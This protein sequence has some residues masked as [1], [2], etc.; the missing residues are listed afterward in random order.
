VLTGPNFG[1]WNRV[2][3]DGRYLSFI[4]ED[5]NNLGV[6]EL[7]TGRVR[8]VTS[9]GIPVDKPGEQYP[10]Q[11]VFSP[12]SRQIA[13]GWCFEDHCVLRVV[14][15]TENSTATRSTLYDNAGVENISPTDWSPDGKWISAMIQR[16]DRTAQIGLVNVADGSL[17]GPDIAPLF[18]TVEDGALPAGDRRKA[19]I[20]D[21][22]GQAFQP[23]ALALCGSGVRLQSLILQ[24]RSLHLQFVHLECGDVS[25]LSIGRDG[26]S[27]ARHRLAKR[28]RA[29]R[30]CALQ[31]VR[32]SV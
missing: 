30:A 28:S 10:L 23:D 13:Y 24:A 7:T 12:D 9:D 1:S 8:P 4:M 27:I 26:A 6:R 11:S 2:S 32:L 5:S 14:A 29:S 20:P 17:F 3:P 18:G 16:K 15:T 19:L 22:V 31:M 21:H 25:P